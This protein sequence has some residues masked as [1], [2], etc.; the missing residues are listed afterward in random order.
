MLSL[1]LGTRKSRLALAQSESVARALEDLHP[2]LKV[3]IVALESKG[4]RTPGMLAPL[5]GKGL[6]TEELERGLLDGDL[7]LAVH[8]LK[9]LPVEL[10]DDLVVAAYPERADPRDVLVSEAAETLEGLP[11]GAAVL[12]G[13]LRRQAQVL[14]THPALQV[15]GIRGNV[16]TRL[17][18]W[19]DQG[20]GG[21]I[22]AA[23]GLDR[24]ALTDLPAHRLDPEAFVPAPGQGT[25]AVQVRSG[26]EAEELC[27]ALAHPET[28]LA[29]EAERRVVAAFGGD[30]TLPLG[31]WARPADGGD[32]LALTALLATPDGRRVARARAAAGSPEEVAAACVASMREQGA[33]DILEAIG[34]PPAP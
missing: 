20:A 10:P 18:K 32:G 21:V 8:S 12:T 17:R 16:Q 13:A 24:L 27:L 28:T 23:A 4:D 14:S 7:D 3:E 34:R 19:R 11:S 6:F 30:C 33:D 25:L 22:L 15:E 9:D 2:G 1:R 31:A 29:A 26:S 5:G